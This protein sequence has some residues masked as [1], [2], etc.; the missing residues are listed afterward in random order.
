MADTIAEIESFC[1]V[2]KTSPDQWG[3]PYGFFVKVTT[4]DGLVGFGESDTMPDIAQ[5]VINARAI[6][7][8]VTG[9]REL[10]LGSSAEPL[11]AWERMR[12]A[13][14]QYGR[15]GAVLHAMAAIDIALWDIAGK[16]ANKSVAGLLGGMKHPRLRCYGTQALGETLAEN[17]ENAQAVVA[18][19]FSAV[20]LGWPPF[21]LAPDHDEAIVRALRDA[22]GPSVDLLI[23]AG[24]A[25]DLTAARA[26]AERLRI[27]DLFWLEEPFAAYDIHSYARFRTEAGIPIAA[28]EMA[29]SASE[30][31]RLIDSRCI[32]VLQI[33]VSRTGLT[34]AAQI[35]QHANRQGIA[36]VNH[37]YSY[38]A[39]A[40]ASA[41][42]MA[43]TS[44]ISLFE[45]QAR[46][47][48]IRSAINRGQ[49]RPKDGWIQ[50]PEAPG[51]G[52]VVDEGALSYFARG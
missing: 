32:D 4:S 17:A 52:I 28:G 12:D 40:A 10:L 14:A 8:L 37:T 3:P 1:L 41:Q 44:A 16:R 25:W 2:G 26:R 7:S 42:L 47:N 31:R 6:N 18:Q 49:L 15:D 43:A 50:V 27:Y 13:V 48:E 23:D 34:Q 22:V 5:A 39:N 33:D 38:I 29:A 11:S 20:K 51:L 24:M 30:L 9:L 21:G 35:A 36:I 46:D 19:G 45:C